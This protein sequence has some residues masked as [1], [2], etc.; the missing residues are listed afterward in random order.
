VFRGTFAADTLI[1]HKD[2]EK[3]TL[4]GVETP[5][6]VFTASIEYNTFDDKSKL[7]KVSFEIF[8]N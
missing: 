6:P 8:M 5:S 4:Q 3:I 1:D 2:T 7:E